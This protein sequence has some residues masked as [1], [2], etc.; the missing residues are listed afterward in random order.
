[1]NVSDN[2]ASVKSLR[3]GVVGDVGICECS[4]NEIINLQLNVESC[5]GCE[6]L[7]VFRAGYYS[8]NHVIE[9]W[10]LA[11]CC[12]RLTTIKHVGGRNL[13]IGLQDPSR[14]CKPLVKV[15]PSQASIK[16]FWLLYKC[17]KDP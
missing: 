1:M 7:Y 12:E 15:C 17:E 9:T 10:N 13:R 5:I 2:F 8:R 11:H 4:G 3:C 6:I 16:L 14:F